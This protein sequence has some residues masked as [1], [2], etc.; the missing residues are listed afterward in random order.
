MESQ[1]LPEGFRDSLPGL[2]DKEYRINSI[3]FDVMESN[4]FLLVK[5]PLMEFE[6]SLFFLKKDNGDVNAFRLIDPISQKMMSIREDITMQVARIACGSLKSMQRPLR[7]MYSGDVLRIKNNNLNMSRQSTQIG[8]EMIGI[9]DYYCENELTKLIIEILE[10]L[11]IKDFFLSFSIPTLISA[12]ASDFN[13]NDSELNNLKNK[14]RNKN[15]SG[16]E[17]ISG[18]LK[19]VCNI[20]H[21]CIGEIKESIDKLKSFK[22][23]KK[24][25]TEINK[26][27]EI[28]TKLDKEF[29]RLKILLDPLEID[30]LNY[31]TGITFRIYSSNFKLLFSGGKYFAYDENCIG[32][33]GFL[34][35]LV[36]ESKIEI[37]KKKRIFV[38][39]DINK[40]LWSKIN[41]SYGVSKLL[42][43]N[44]IPKHLD[45]NL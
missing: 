5:P 9:K 35:N 4:G 25:Q 16:V 33:S 34:D 42:S 15:F 21:L 41:N 1:L 3:F 29:P 31:H 26:Y 36:I 6:E 32:F 7:I 22:F 28:T 20:L 40:N 12:L 17:K 27:T 23:P 2:A 38:E 10:K 39:F 30:E 14:F 37:S 43:L 24:T 45:N 13:L 11:K 8:G 18:E 19:K 44:G